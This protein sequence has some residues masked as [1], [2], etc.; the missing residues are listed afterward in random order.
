[1]R[2]SSSSMA[3]RVALGEGKICMFGGKGGEKCWLSWVVCRRS[4]CCCCST[5]LLCREQ[6]NKRGP[7]PRPT[8]TREAPRVAKNNT[9]K[10]SGE[11]PNQPSS[12]KF[13]R[14]S[15]QMVRVLHSSNG[16][17]MVLVFGASVVVAAADPSIIFLRGGGFK[18]VPFLR[19]TTLN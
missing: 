6:N 8:Y 10:A 5:S 3:E 17:A 16:V 14:R 15:A 13:D 18:K 11:K 4:R 12:I 7:G 1:M 19:K 2:D 9:S